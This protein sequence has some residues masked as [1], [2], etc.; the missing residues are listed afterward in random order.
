VL[1]CRADLL[2]AAINRLL[3][4]P[5]LRSCFGE[6]AAWRVRNEFTIEKMTKRTLEIYSEALETTAA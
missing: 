6:A 4:D 1:P 5:Q 2:A 3:D